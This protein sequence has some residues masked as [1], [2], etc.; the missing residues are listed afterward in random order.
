MSQHVILLKQVGRAL[1]CGVKSSIVTWV[2]NLLN[3]P[4]SQ[5]AYVVF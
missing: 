1:S 4:I 3:S 2:R 5:N